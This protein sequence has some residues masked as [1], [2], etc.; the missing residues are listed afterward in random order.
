M[1]F[2]R[3]LV[4][5]KED[6]IDAFLV[7]GKQKFFC[8]G[9]NK[10]GTT[11]LMTTFKRFGFIVGNQHRAE[12]LIDDYI[13]SD[14][15]SL[16][17][18]CRTAEVFQDFPFSFPESYKI[19]DEAFPGSKFILSVRN[20]P[21]EWYNS[22]IRFHSKIF[23][24]GN[25]PTVAQLKYA[26]YVHPGWIW[27][28]MQ[29]LYHVSELNPYDKEKLIKRYDEHNAEVIDYFSDRK[30]DLLVINLSEA[31]AYQRFCSFIG[32]GDDRNGQF[33]WENRTK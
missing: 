11:S 20:S 21:D 24:R 9:A 25:L 23:G 16:L 15:T 31:E 3:K 19:V 30:D 28:A 14:F 29:H 27:K 13:S 10:T 2:K 18:Y 32:K 5:F 7:K 33:P 26:R 6:I 17:K 12:S 8:I 22:V 4:W 1:I